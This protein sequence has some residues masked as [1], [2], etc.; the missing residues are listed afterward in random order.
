MRFSLFSG[1]TLAASIMFVP[2]AQA[3]ITIGLIAPVTGPVAA[4]GIQVQNGTESA[5]DAASSFCMRPRRMLRTSFA[6][7]PRTSVR[8]RV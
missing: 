7:T 1:V 2:L 3:D 5:V 4:Y 8:R 6:I